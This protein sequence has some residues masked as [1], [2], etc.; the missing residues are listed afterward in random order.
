MKHRP[1]V[2]ILTRTSGR[3]KYFERCVESIKTQTYPHINHI[4]SVDDSESE[5]YVKKHTENYIRVS[6]VT[7]PIPPDP[8][9]IRRP[10]P[11]NLYLN[12]LRD[13]VERGWI[14]Y[15][16]DDDE[17]LVNTAIEELMDIAINEDHMLIWKVK[18]PNRTIPG[19]DLFNKKV[20]AMN[21]FSMIGFMYHKKYDRFSNFDYYSAGDFH[22]VKDLAPNIPNSLWVDKV[23]TGIQRDE[24]M[25]GFGKRDDK[26]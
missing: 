11:Y 15:L 17:F 9:K 23:Y 7:N 18:F 16:D 25:G 5:E 4:V 12:E 20:I 10:A 26:K 8:K 14:M 13:K 1:M 24:N 22:F 6:R 19:D 21:H 2:N 3:P